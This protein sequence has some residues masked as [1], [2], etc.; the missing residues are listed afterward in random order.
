MKHKVV[1]ASEAVAL[2]RDGDTL[3]NTGFVGS[4]APGRLCWWRWNSASSRPARR[5]T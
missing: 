2:I 5:A 1:T 4:G 3:V